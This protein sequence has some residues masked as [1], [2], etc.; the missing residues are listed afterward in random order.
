[1]QLKECKNCIL[2]GT[3]GRMAM[4]L[5]S[6][7]KIKLSN[8]GLLNQT[9]FKKSNFCFQIEKTGRTKIKRSSLNATDQAFYSNE[10]LKSTKSPRPSGEE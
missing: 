5:W 10:R 6:Q 3:P 4:D 8:P 2:T 7:M 1:M 9:S